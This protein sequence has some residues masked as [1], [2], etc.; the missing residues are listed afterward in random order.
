MLMAVDG[1]LKLDNTKG[2]SKVDGHT[3]E[4]DILD[5]HF[6]L[7]HTGS[8]A[9]GR[10]GG[11]AKVDFH[12]LSVTKRFDKASPVLM[13]MCADGTHIKNGLITL[14]KAAGTEN[15]P[16]DYL[17]IKMEDIIISQVTHSGLGLTVPLIHRKNTDRAAFIGA[18]I[19]IVPN[20]ENPGYYN[21]TIELRPHYQ[22]EDV[23]LNFAKIVMDYTEQTETGDK[24]DNVTFG[25][26]VK[27]NKKIG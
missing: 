23:T 25:W 1:F 5:V 16:L 15:K 14:R 4:I 17:K 24:G 18:N 9:F 13:G 21:A 3:G 7:N 26:D 2:E 19:T 10:G 6:A 22:L 27:A 20:E 11:T 8:G 12:N